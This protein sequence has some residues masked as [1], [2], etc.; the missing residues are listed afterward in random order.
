MYPILK[1]VRLGGEAAPAQT[2]SAKVS[3]RK[4]AA[5]KTSAKPT[6]ETDPGVETAASDKVVEPFFGDLETHR[7]T[8]FLEYHARSVYFLAN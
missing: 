4:T 8:Y 6:P 5:E 1:Q 3:A 7:A 2:K